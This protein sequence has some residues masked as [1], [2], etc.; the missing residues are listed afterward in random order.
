VE[1]IKEGVVVTLGRVTMLIVLI[2]ITML[3]IWCGKVIYRVD[4]IYQLKPLS[5]RLDLNRGE[6]MLRGVG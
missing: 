1:G 4:L 2:S 3:G 5:L 6:I